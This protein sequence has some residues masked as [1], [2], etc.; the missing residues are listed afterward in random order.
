MSAY[1]IT[2]EGGLGEGG[3]DILPDGSLVDD[4]KRF[5]AM[6]VVVGSLLGDNAWYRKSNKDIQ[7]FHHE[8]CRY[9]LRVS[10]SGAT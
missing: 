7:V 3:L 9:Q 1:F 5:E 2:W 4:G 10:R 6:V 8:G